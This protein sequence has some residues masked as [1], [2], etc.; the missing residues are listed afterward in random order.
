M[1]L[2]HKPIYTNSYDEYDDE[3]GLK[4]LLWSQFGC[5]CGRCDISSG[6]RLMDKIPVIVLDQIAQEERMLMDIE[7]GYTC[8]PHADEISLPSMDSHRAGLAVRIRVV[9]PKKRMLITRG[10][11]IR[12]V[13]RIGINEKYLYYDTDDLKQLALYCR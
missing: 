13:T 8:K 11:I 3:D 6:K 5:K 4:K 2:L 10:L 12:G 7:L 1:S 9:N